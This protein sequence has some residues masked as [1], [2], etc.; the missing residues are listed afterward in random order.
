LLLVPLFTAA[1]VVLVLILPRDWA[2]LRGP[3]ELSFGFFVATYPTRVAHAALTGLQEFAF[4]GWIQ[5]LSGVLN[6]IAT[7]V[8]VALGFGLYAVALGPVL[9]QLVAIVGWIVRL[10]R[11]HRAILPTRI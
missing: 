5:A 7:A 3:L 2:A 9:G 6:L 11:V 1:S 8:F 4:L 10:V